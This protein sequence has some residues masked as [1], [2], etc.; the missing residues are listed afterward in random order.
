MV[1]FVFDVDGVLTNLGQTIEPKHKEFFLNWM[2]GKSV[3]LASGSD[4]D[5]TKR[6]LGEEIVNAVQSSFNCLGNSVWTNGVEEKRNDFRLT[7]IQKIFLQLQINKSAY[8]VRTGNHIE[9][10]TGVVNFSI[11]GR[12]ANQEQ[13]ERYQKWDQEFKERERICKEFMGLF[14]AFSANIGGM[15]SID[16]CKVGCDKR[17]V[18]DYI[19]KPVIFFGDRCF[20]GGID[21]PLA[22]R[23]VNEG[24]VVHHIKNFEETWEILNRYV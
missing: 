6:Q 24:D 7:D 23:C 22:D 10:R 12:N 15:I 5:K 16:I 8:S 20:P 17:Q 4:M 19:P 2:K 11:V 1:S 3:F 18:Y 13:R 14:P 9:E 21:K